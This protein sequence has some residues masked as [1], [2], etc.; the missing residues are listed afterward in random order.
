MNQYLLLNKYQPVKVYDYSFDKATSNRYIILKDLILTESVHLLLI[1][2]AGSGKTTFL[3]TLIYE[4]YN[5]I[6]KKIIFENCLYI[7]NLKD[8]GINYYRNDVKTFCQTSSLIPNKKKLVILDDID[9]L[10]EQSQQVFRNLID[11]YGNNI[12][13]L[14][15]CL[16]IQKVIESIQSR[17]YISKLPNITK[18]II[19]DVFNK[20]KINENIQIDKPAKDFIIKLCNNNIKQLITYM[21]KFKLYNKQI[22]IKVVNNLCCNIN[23]CELEKFTQSLIN[24]DLI[25]S[26]DIIYNIYDT[27]Y[28]VMDILDTY[29]IFIKNTSILDETIK[30]QMIPIIC[31]YITFFYSV[32]EDE[33]E[34]SFFTNNLIQLFNHNN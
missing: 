30:Y 2:F 12:L 8:Q 3:E 29:F 21:E 25:Q 19:T 33:I 10:N 17:F 6:D 27:G 32:H 26:L 28:S 4:Y 31:K 18:E 15:S 13:F 20:I 14:A 24:G 23:F 7:N 16:N 22:D 11:K 34:L 1:G 9:L 5:Y